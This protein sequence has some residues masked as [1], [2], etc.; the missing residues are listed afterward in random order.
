MA[1]TIAEIQAEIIAAKNADNVLA[2]LDSG[3]ATAV[4]RLWTRIVAAAHAALDNIF[5]LHKAEVE[6]LI[7]ERRPHTLKWY[8]QIALRFQYGRALPE[9]Q[10]YFDNTGVS[11]D[12][13]EAER[14]IAQA[15]AVEEAGRLVLK[16]AKEDS[17]EL[18]PLDNTELAAF[19]DYMAEVK[20]AGVTLSIRTNAADKIKA[21]IDVYYDPG[22]LSASGARL[23]GSAGSPVQDAA[24]AFLRNAPFN[25]V[26]VRAHFVDALQAI[27]GVYVPEVRSVQVARADSSTFVEVNVQYQPFAG[28]LKFYDPAD[29][30]VNFISQTTL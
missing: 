1:R 10:I 25:G 18:E 14:I 3:S 17:G 15:A 21:V 28:F 7:D 30:D 22:L 27:E 4:W 20:D 5:D 23:D 24:R 12:V 16:I 2:D 26:F 11:V 6:R 13:V 19:Q 29:L 9:G 8:Q